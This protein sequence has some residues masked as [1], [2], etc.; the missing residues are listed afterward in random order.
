M[1]DTEWFQPD[2]L[3]AW[4]DKLA[5][6]GPVIWVHIFMNRDSLCVPISFDPTSP[7]IGTDRRTFEALR[8]WYSFM[9]VKRGLSEIILP[10]RLMRIYKVEVGLF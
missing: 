2:Y 6:E 10:R 3:Q 8:M 5:R 1:V 9:C 7:D 4:R